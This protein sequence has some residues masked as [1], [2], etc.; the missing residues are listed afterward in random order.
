VLLVAQAAVV[1]A[2]VLMI[3]QVV[4]VYQ[5]KV[6]RVVQVKM[7][8][9]A[10]FT[11]GQRLVAVEVVRVRLVQML[12]RQLVAMVVQVAIL[13]QLGQAQLQLV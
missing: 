12:Q 4:L 10:Q 6:L 3:L 9:L 5:G 2:T 1:H 11:L 8:I 7:G 13:T